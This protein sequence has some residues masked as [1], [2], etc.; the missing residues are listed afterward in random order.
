[1]DD[2][3]TGIEIQTRTQ[4]IPVALKKEDEVQNYCLQF[5]QFYMVHMNL[6]DAIKE[7]DI[8]RT[9]NS[10][11]VMAPFFF[12]MSQNSKYFV[13][14]LDYI[15]KTEILLPPKL[16]LQVRAGSTVNPKGKKGKNKAAD[17]Q[18]ENQVK[19]LKGLI[20][21]LGSNKT[22]KSIIGIS[23]AYPLLKEITNHVDSQIHYKDIKTTHKSRSQDEDRNALIDALKDLNIFD[24]RPGRIIEGYEGIKPSIFEEHCDKV[25]QYKVKVMDTINRLKRGVPV[26]TDED[27]T[28]EANPE[29]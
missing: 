18:K 5:L 1:M 20:K 13:E 26:A 9:S 19:E 12:C 6:K 24:T 25:E 15:L 27:D 2:V 28:A 21:G 11:K 14:T 4:V 3:K 10:L 16:A 29:D 23:K 17:L 7:G 22:E 8:C